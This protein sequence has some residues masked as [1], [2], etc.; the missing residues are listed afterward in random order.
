LQV[1]GHGLSL[2][3]PVTLRKWDLIL[4][5]IIPLH[6]SNGLLNPFMGFCFKSYPEKLYL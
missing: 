2:E 1:A 4:A 6:T 3:T 5:K